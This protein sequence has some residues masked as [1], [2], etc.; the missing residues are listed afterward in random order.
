[1][2]SALPA[3]LIVKN[4]FICLKEDWGIEKLVRHSSC[5]PLR[6]HE[7]DCS[8]EASTDDDERCGAELALPIAGAT[9][10]ASPA[11]LPVDTAQAVVSEVPVK[12][13]FIHYEETVPLCRHSSSPPRNS[14]VEDELPS[15][16]A[17]GCE[18]RDS[19][20]PLC[21]LK[22]TMSVHWADYDS[23]EPQHDAT[24]NS[25]TLEVVS[26]S[27]RLQGKRRCSAAQTAQVAQLARA[28]QPHPS[29]A[30][31]AS[32]AAKASQLHWQPS[33]R[34]T[35]KRA[36]IP[37]APGPVQGCML[38]WQMEVGMVEDKQFHV[39]RHLIGKGGE[40]MKRIVSEAGGKAAKVS[41]N[42]RGHGSRP[43]DDHN[44]KV[45]EPLMMLVS[46]AQPE[47]FRLAVDLTRQ[48]ILQVREEHRTWQQQEST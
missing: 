29:Q 34:I 18:A 36:T 7:A 22:P 4:T 33:R 20:P 30:A 31:E 2:A 48:L 6:L 1:M 32:K 17:G 43:S 35:E 16:V 11:D 27:W 12:N 26:P 3:P 45:K 13:T 42:L 25:N 39:C 21:G 10:S 14:V 15:E 47:A 46:A 41:V 9:T 38:T 23:D 28:P 37:V 44:A 5:P 8:S 40:N 24:S 19:S